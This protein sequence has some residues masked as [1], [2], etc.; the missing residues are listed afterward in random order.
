MNFPND[1]YGHYSGLIRYCPQ[2]VG[3]TLLKKH[4]FLKVTNAF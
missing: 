1:Y 3:L 2:G 4:N